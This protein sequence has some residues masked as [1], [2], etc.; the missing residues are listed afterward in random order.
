MRRSVSDKGKGNNSLSIA[1]QIADCKKSLKE[2]KDFKLYCDDG[3]S[4][5]NTDRPEFQRMMSDV[6][7]GLVGRIIVKK[8]DRF[9]RST[10]DF[11][12]VI[13]E[14]EQHGVTLVSVQENID[15]ATIAGRMMRDVI[16]SFASFERET[17]AARVADA[18]GTRANETG[19]YQGGQKCYGYDSERRIVNGKM[20]SVLVPN[21]QA[22]A[23][24]AAYRLYQNPS[25]SLQDIVDYCLENGIEVRHTKESD[26]DRSHFS[27]V[28]GVPLYVRAD[29]EVYQYL[30]ST[31]VE[32][33]DDIEAFNGVHGMF[34]HKR[35]DGSVFVKMGYHKGLVDSETW[36]AVQD[37]KSQHKQVPRNTDAKNFW[38]V[39]LV[40]CA[41]CGCSRW[42]AHHARCISFRPHDK[43]PPRPLI[44][45]FLY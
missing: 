38:L 45:L 26:M 37:R 29:K 5:K 1:S 16:L 35:A 15:A 42:Y 44:F 21:A 6:R 20:G 9:S 23:V 2:G 3:K 32:I 11:H 27:R 19:F 18:Y 31:G 25:N 39:G 33:I 4:A 41:S 12:N 17:I 7:D 14:L 24:R 13:E 28:L 22:E 8:Y 30:T 40:K 10:R 34:T 43:P 36:L